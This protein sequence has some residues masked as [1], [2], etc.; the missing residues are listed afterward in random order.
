MS[1]VFLSPKSSQQEICY[2]CKESIG[3]GAVWRW[4]VAQDSLFAHCQCVKII[5][6]AQ[7]GLQTRI[8][9]LDAKVR[10]CAYVHAISRVY[11]EL[12]TESLKSFIG[13]RGGDALERLLNTVGMAAVENFKAV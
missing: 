11:E 12:N 7:E 6:D 1:F 8:A 13:I 5:S 4:S 2:V 10:S 3:E 9:Q